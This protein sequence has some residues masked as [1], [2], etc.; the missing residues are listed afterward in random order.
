MGDAMLFMLEGATPNTVSTVI[1][2]LTNGL[3]TAGSDLL[4]AI[5]TIVPVAVPVMIAIV[6]IGVGL[7]IFKKVTGR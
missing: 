7:K 4:G 6:G 1:D 3:S 5:A 2:A